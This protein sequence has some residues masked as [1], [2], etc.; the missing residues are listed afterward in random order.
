MTVIPCNGDFYLC[1]P[2]YESAHK[3]V[4]ITHAPIIAWEIDDGMYHP[5]CADVLF[6]EKPHTFVI[7][8][9][10]RF[11]SY[12]LGTMS[13]KEQVIKEFQEIADKENKQHDRRRTD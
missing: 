11:F 7:E 4:D 12:C 2:V 1:E 3:V 10:S 8:H 13:N 6:N 5:I 9:G